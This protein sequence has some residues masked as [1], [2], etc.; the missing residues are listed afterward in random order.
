MWIEGGRCLDERGAGGEGKLR[1]QLSAQTQSY[2]DAGLSELVA[3]VQLEDL[4]GT[5]SSFMSYSC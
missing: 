5:T 3:H 4:V 2:W 1:G